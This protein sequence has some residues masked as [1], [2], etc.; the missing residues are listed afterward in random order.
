MGYFV[1]LPDGM[2]LQRQPT[3]CRFSLWTK[4]KTTEKIPLLLFLKTCVGHFECM[5]VHEYVCACKRLCDS[6]KLLMLVLLL[7]LLVIVLCILCV[8]FWH[9]TCKERSIHFYS[10]SVNTK[11][12][13]R[14]LH[15]SRI[16]TTGRYTVLWRS[17]LLCEYTKLRQTSCY[18]L[19]LQKE[20]NWNKI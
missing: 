17:N 5:H 18:L 15:C 10:R 13:F 12:S 8:C 2:K 20:N 14:S 1:M 16:N 6:A 11:T 19:Y 7:L 4:S 9:E 3:S